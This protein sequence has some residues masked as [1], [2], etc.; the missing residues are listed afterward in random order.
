MACS[1]VELESGNFFITGDATS[2]LTGSFSTL[3]QRFRIFDSTLIRS[4]NTTISLRSYAPTQQQHFE[5]IDQLGTRFGVNLMQFSGADSTDDSFSSKRTRILAAR[6]P[7]QSC[8]DLIKT[9]ESPTTQWDTKTVQPVLCALWRA[10]MTYTGRFG[11]TLIVSLPMEA[12]ELFEEGAELAAS[13]AKFSGPFPFQGE[14]GEEKAVILSTTGECSTR[15]PASQYK[16]KLPP[17]VTLASDELQ[18]Q[19]SQEATAT[20]DEHDRGLSDSTPPSI[21]FDASELTASL[22]QQQKY[23][24][25]HASGQFSLQASPVAVETKVERVPRVDEGQPAGA[26]TGPSI[27]GEPEQGGAPRYEHWDQQRV[28]DSHRPL[29]Q[30]ASNL[31][32]Q[33]PTSRRHVA[34]IGFS[35]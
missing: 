15:V 21:F 10:C 35:V 2:S 19:L 16:C 6:D 32:V 3:E 18:S 28:D 17:M 12:S 23:N 4:P 5:M 34:T 24:L 7:L 26:F 29:G 8:D 30:S 11:T 27:G 1:E 20:P 9:L 31:R 33:G 13:V 14:A 22:P 25:D